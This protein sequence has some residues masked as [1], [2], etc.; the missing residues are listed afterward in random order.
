MLLA[1][2]NQQ[3]SHPMQKKRAYV[4]GKPEHALKLETPSKMLGKK[5][6]HLCKYCLFYN[7]NIFTL[8]TFLKQSSRTC[9]TSSTHKTELISLH[10]LSRLCWIRKNK[11]V[12]LIRVFRTGIEN[13][14]GRQGSIKLMPG[15]GLM[16]TWSSTFLKYTCNRYTSV[17]TGVWSTPSPLDASPHCDVLDKLFMLN[18]EHGPTSDLI[19]FV[20]SMDSMQWD[21]HRYTFRKKFL[22]SRWYGWH[23]I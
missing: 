23:L 5:L 10:D 8:H 3:Q 7:L 17:L 1:E 12:R 20:L 22:L 6:I 2:I 4:I 15:P 19:N 11:N 13:F 14:C 9:F 16:N 18:Q 21:V